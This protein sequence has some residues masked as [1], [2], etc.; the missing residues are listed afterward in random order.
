MS[1]VDAEGTERASL[2]PPFVADAS[3]PAGD[4]AGDGPGYSTEAVSLRIVEWAPELVVRLA[5][6][7]AWLAAPERAWPVVVDPTVTITGS[8]HDTY[9]GS[10]TYANTNYGSSTIMGIGGG[11]SRFRTLQQRDVASFFSEPAVITGANLELYATNDTSASAQRSVAI[12]E[13]VSSWS[14][15]QATWNNRLTSTPWSSGGG[16]FDPVPLWR[17]NGIIGAVGWRQF[18]VT[19]AVQGWVDGTKANHGVLIKYLDESAGPQVVFASANASDSTKRPRMVVN[20]EPLQGLRD[21]YGYQDFDLGGAGLAKVNLASGNLT[22]VEADLDTPGSGL[23][24]LVQR[25]YNSRA[26]YQGSLGARWTMWPQSKER[27]YEGAAK[28]TSWR[29]GPAERLVF[30]PTGR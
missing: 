23:D 16:S 15:A 14:S 2:A 19:R 7:P 30:S 4:L 8:N 26:P 5:V 21:I 27:L 18:P 28:D 6:D 10:G 24:A 11:T 9:L 1:I 12:H 17:G 13:V 29:G 22:M 20:W 3:H 25:F